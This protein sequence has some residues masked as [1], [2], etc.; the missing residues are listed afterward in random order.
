MSGST[1]APIVK[2]RPLDKLKDETEPLKDSPGWKALSAWIDGLVAT[3]RTE[4]ETVAPADA[5]RISSLQAEIRAY[6]LVQGLV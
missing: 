4:L 5:V 6:R 2:Q 1:P 3:A